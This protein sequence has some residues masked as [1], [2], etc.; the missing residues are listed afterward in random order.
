MLYT[1]KRKEKQLKLVQS[2]SK[3][4]T[5]GDALFWVYSRNA[6]LKITF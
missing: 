2:F 5:T 6:D 4:F 3:N 1:G